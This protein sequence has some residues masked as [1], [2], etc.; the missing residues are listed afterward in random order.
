MSVCQTCHRGQISCRGECATCYSYRYTHGVARPTQLIDRTTLSS[1][2]TEATAT[3]AEVCQMTG[4]TYRQLD[5]WTRN[6][7]I[8]PSVQSALG[9]GA[10]R[11]WAVSDV[12][13][14]ATVVA[15]INWGMTVEAAF[16]TDDPPL[17]T[18]AAEVKP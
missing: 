16:R 18:F 6:G 13:K 4:A 5:Y 2:D 15:R 1:R 14:I 9:S 17:P 10:V 12:D 7:L 8:S 11:L 3:T